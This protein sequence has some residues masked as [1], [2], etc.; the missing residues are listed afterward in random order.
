MKFW[1]NHCLP[2]RFDNRGKIF[3][4]S[5]DKNRILPICC[6]VRRISFT[7]SDPFCGTACVCNASSSLAIPSDNSLFPISIWYCSASTRHLAAQEP[8]PVQFVLCSFVATPGI[9]WLLPCFFLSAWRRRHRILCGGIVSPW[10]LVPRFAPAPYGSQM[11]SFGILHNS[12]QKWS[13]WMRR[14]DVVTAWRQIVAR[15]RLAT[16]AFHPTST[17]VSLCRSCRL[18]ALLRSLGL[19]S[20]CNERTCWRSQDDTECQSKHDKDSWTPRPLQPD[21]W[22]SVTRCASHCSWIRVDFDKTR[23]ANKIICQPFSFSH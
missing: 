6:N 2:S 12:T 5:L 10:I 11:C 16:N 4:C 21:Y 23:V 20:L 14:E 9:Q 1:E 17:A 18:R 8:S 22:L 15:Q 7:N 19:D 13:R 3:P